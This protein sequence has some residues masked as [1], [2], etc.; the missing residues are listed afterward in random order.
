MRLA[1]RRLC[2]YRRRPDGREQALLEDVCAEFSPGR[3]VLITGPNG[4]G[5]STLLHVLAGFLRPSAGEVLA[6]GAAMS[7]WRSHYRDRF[8]RR[9]GF[10]FQHFNL[11]SGLSTVE[12]VILPLIPRGGSLAEMQTAAEL[13]L[14]A[15]AISHLAAAPAAALSGGEAQRAAF[16]RALACDP[17]I[18]LADEPTAFQDQEGVGLMAAAFRGWKAK[19]ATVVVTGH[20]RCLE[21]EPGLIDYRYRMENG[22]LEAA[23]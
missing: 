10:V 11:L 19:G 7:R 15:L 12:N 23:G 21:A 6:D 20:D 16:A 17:V 18:V 13:A 3:A 2:L 9:V 4:A 14:N 8:R 1:C 5:K 22:R